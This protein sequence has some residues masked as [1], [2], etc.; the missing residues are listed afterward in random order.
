MAPLHLT[1]PPCTPPP[2]ERTGEPPATPQPQKAP[3]QRVMRPGQGSRGWWPIDHTR[4]LSA[5]GLL[6]CRRRPQELETGLSAAQPQA[7]AR[8]HERH[9]TYSLC[10]QWGPCN[11]AHERHSTGIGYAHSGAAHERH[12]TCN[13]LCSQWG[14]MH[15]RTVYIGCIGCDSRV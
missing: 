9:R 15:R 4:H 14:T 10:S 8:A 2:T 13:W 11:N 3:G 1:M 6:C 12:S 7:P 5:R